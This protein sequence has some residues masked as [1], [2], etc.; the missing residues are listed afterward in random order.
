MRPESK[1]RKI[2]TVVGG[3]ADGCKESLCALIGGETAEMPGLYA[4]EEYD[5]AG[6]SVGIVDKNIIDGHTIKEG[7]VVPAWHR[8]QFTFQRIFGKK[9]VF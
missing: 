6:F 7:D 2:A 4:E 3:I 5:L 1:S 9:I 8:E